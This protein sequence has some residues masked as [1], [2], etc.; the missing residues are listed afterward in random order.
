MQS[1]SCDT[2][3]LGTLWVL[4]ALRDADECTAP[5]ARVDQILETR[6]AERN[7]TASRYTAKEDTGG[8]REPGECA[9]LVGD[10]G[11]CLSAA[12]LTGDVPSWL[13]LF[14]RHII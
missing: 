1:K 8:S 11:G 7:E 12:E 2:V 5:A 3:G 13:L 9:I 14:S 4:E 6:C 10:G